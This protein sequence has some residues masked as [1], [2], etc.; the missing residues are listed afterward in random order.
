MS[1]AFVNIRTMIHFYGEE[2]FAFRP[3]PEL[4]DHPLSAVRDCLFNIFA[5]TLLIGGRSS[6]RTR[7][8]AMPWLQGPTYRASDDTSVQ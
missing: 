4:E 6:N 1:E 8:R 2:L 5:A 3:T 7:S